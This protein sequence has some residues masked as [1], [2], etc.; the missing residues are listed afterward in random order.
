M[1][2]KLLPGYAHLGL[3]K[4][5]HRFPDLSIRPSNSLDLAIAGTIEFQTEHRDCGTILESFHLEIRVPQK[6]PRVLPRVFEPKGRIPNTF[7]HN[8]NR[9]LCLG[10]LLRLQLI[11]QHDPTLLGFLEGCVIPYLINFAVSERTGKLPLGEL[12]HG[13]RGLLDDY[14]SILRANSD[15]CC[16]G[17]LE[18]LTLKKRI[19][20][21]KPCPCGGGKRLGRCHHKHLNK[22][23][24]RAPRSQ[25]G[26]VLADLRRNLAAEARSRPRANTP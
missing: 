9:E 8:G 20:N 17:L 2:G 12:E 18:L 7:H 21:K 22:V 4:L 5:F 6:F 14:R 15:Q 3:D 10:S 26:V 1:Q 13:A 23:R 19:A 11:V 16:L 24:R 25:F